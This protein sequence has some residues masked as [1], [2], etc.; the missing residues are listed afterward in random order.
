MDQRW[1]NEWEWR[2]N[3][4]FSKREKERNVPQTTK[5]FVD[6]VPLVKPLLKTG[7]QNMCR[8]NDERNHFRVQVSQLQ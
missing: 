1:G 7:L 3:D 8:K 5:C 6:S 2:G 4:N